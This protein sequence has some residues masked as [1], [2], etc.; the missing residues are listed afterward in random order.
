MDECYKISNE[1]FYICEK[2]MFREAADKTLD[3]YM[4][5]TAPIIYIIAMFINNNL[6]YSSI[7]ELNIFTAFWFVAYMEMVLLFWLVPYKS[8]KKKV[9]INRVNQENS[10][11]FVTYDEAKKFVLSNI[12]QKNSAQYLDYYKTTEEIKKEWNK[13]SPSNKTI[14]LNIIFYLKSNLLTKFLGKTSSIA[15]TSLI[16]AFVNEKY[17]NLWGGFKFR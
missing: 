5:V 8:A 3:I 12:T 11:S 4:F 14:I 7:F 16:A 13:F 15:L 1:Y 9:F 2:G 17:P 10:T 6:G